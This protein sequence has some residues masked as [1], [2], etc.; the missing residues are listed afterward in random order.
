MQDQEW[1]VRL[2][3]GKNCKFSS[4]DPFRVNERKRLITETGPKAQASA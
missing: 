1:A 2:T 3:I 4:V